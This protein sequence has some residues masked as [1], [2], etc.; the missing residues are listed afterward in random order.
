[1]PHISVITDR[2]QA[3]NYEWSV[4]TETCGICWRDW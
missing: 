4:M 1:M 3:L 2:S